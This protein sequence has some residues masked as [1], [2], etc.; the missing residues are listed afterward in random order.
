MNNIDELRGTLVLVHPDLTVDPAHKQG[1]IGMVTDIIPDVDNVF[2]SFGHGLQALYSSDALLALRNQREIYQDMLANATK[3]ETPD[4][5][6]LFRL[7]LFQQS[8]QKKDQQ[9]AMELAR[10]NAAVRNYA[11]VSVQEKFGIKEAPLQAVEP[12][13]AIARGR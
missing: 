9:A 10:D 13:L 12:Q 6:A 8:G 4:F 2:V 11:M 1:Q 3:M 7:T 5:K